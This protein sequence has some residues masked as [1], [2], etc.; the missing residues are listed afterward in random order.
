M[1]QV[2]VFAGTSGIDEVFF[3]VTAEP[4]REFIT[5]ARQLLTTYER[6][7]NEN[8]CHPDNAIFIRFHLSD[9]ISQQAILEPLLAGRQGFIS[10][11]GQPPAG[12]ARLALEAW[13]F[14]CRSSEAYHIQMNGNQQF[15]LR[16]KHY[17]LFFHRMTEHAGDDSAT[18]TTG[19][20]EALNAELAKRGGTTTDNCL[21]TWLF[22]RDIDHNYAALASARRE[23][24]AHHGMTPDT[25][26]IASTGIEGCDAA[27]ERL[28]RMDACCL[29]GHRQEQLEYMQ[30]LDHMPPTH[31]YGVTFERGLRVM[32]G[33]RSHYYISGTASIDQTGQIVHPGDSAAQT[34]K[35]VANVKD[36]L[37]RHQGS[38]ADLKIAIIYLRNSTDA[39]IVAAQLQL[40]LPPTLPRL[41]LTAPVCRPGWLVE[42]EAFGV[43]RH[44]LQEF[45]PLC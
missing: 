22:C 14:R 35:M 10:L 43:N 21:R 18:Q 34:V 25:H 33:D 31:L 45:P 38:L 13:H 12:G 17:C 16:L 2:A 36:L 19:E 15:E 6:L 41:I 32:F 42:M 23:W 26:Y 44:G 37:E 29:F 1:S 20:F 39:D 28:V 4:D 40:L 24:F 30:D 11:I 3:A 27:P 9:I 5:E 7:M 8:D